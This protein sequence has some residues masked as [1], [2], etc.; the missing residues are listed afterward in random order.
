MADHGVDELAAELYVVEPA[1]FVALRTAAVAQARAAG[2]RD[3]A[4]AIGRLRR[5]TM[6]A[7]AVNL[8]VRAA[9]GQMSELLLLG[10]QLR[11]AQQQLRGDELR[12]LTQRRRELVGSLT[13]QA[14]RLA[15]D[16]GHRLGGAAL[17]EVEQTL[18]AALADAGSAE[19]VGSG[20][21]ARPLQHVGLGPEPLVAGVLRPAAP[22][23][24]VSG[25]VSGLEQPPSPPQDEIARHRRRRAERMAR[26]LARADQELNEATTRAEHAEQQVRQAEQRSADLQR[27]LAELKRD[28]DRAERDLEQ[29]QRRARSAARVRADAERRVQ[30]LAEQQHEAQ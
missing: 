24:P 25:P 5:P 23:G 22:P 10:E 6:S 12:R 3:L 1:R 7:W 4:T 2:R 8:L 30:R 17:V 20:R 19:A 27:R 13:G 15:A 29:A 28:C 26:D 14:R 16:A 21:L 9:P 11:A 18:G